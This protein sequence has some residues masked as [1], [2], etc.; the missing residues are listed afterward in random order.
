MPQGSILGPKPF[1]GFVKSISAMFVTE[2]SN[3]LFLLTNELKNFNE[4]K[5]AADLEAHRKDF[6]KQIA[7]V[8]LMVWRI[9]QVSA[10][11]N[12]SLVILSK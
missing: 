3:I 2:Y 5:G 7:G 12:P 10:F 8:K 6:T 9:M 4:I 1:Y 11:R